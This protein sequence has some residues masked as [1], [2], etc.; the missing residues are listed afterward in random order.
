MATL[1]SPISAP[2]IT[3]PPAP[4]TAEETG[5]PFSF[6]CDLSLKILYLNGSLLGREVAEQICLPFSL[7]ETTLA[8]LADEGYI[9]SAGM[10]QTQLASYDSLNAAMQWQISTSGRTRAREIME[11]NQYAGPAPVPL[12]TYMAMAHQQSHVEVEVDRQ[13]MRELFTELVVPDSLLDRLGPALSARAATFLYGPPGNGKTSIAE[14]AAK[15]LGPPMFVPRALYSHGEVIRFFDPL[16]HTPVARELPDHDRRW[17]LTERP[18]VKAGGELGPHSLELAFDSTLGFY[19]AS[20]QLKAN[21][22]LF[23][24]DDFGRQQKLS[25][26]DLLNRLIVPLEK[27]VDYLNIARAGTSV[28]VPFTGL[29]LLSTN[30]QPEH[31][32]DE[33]FLRRVRFKVFVPDPTDDEY[34]EIWKRCC[35]R[36]GVPFEGQLIDRLLDQCH[37]AGRALHGVHPRDLLNQVVHTARYLREPVALTPRLLDMACATYFLGE[38]V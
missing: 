32:M 11:L 38:T 30:L 7:L 12:N 35:V 17:L 34:R 33:A 19:E 21:G 31:L 25:P 15:V 27:G 9:T 18:V 36:E 13:T 2:A 3:L 16:H 23:L 1:P 28:P 20:L 37:R 4:R 5:L 6:L 10:R 26:R 24:I 22:G 8:F 14:A 29:L